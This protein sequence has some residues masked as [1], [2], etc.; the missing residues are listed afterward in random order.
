MLRCAAVLDTGAASWPPRWLAMP[1]FQICVKLSHQQGCSKD[2]EEQLPNGQQALM[3]AIIFCIG[4]TKMAPRA[5]CIPLY[6]PWKGIG[7]WPS[8]AHMGGHMG[9]SLRSPIRCTRCTPS[10]R[11][12]CKVSCARRRFHAGCR[13]TADTK[14]FFSSSHKFDRTGTSALQSIEDLSAIR[15]C[16]LG[17][18]MAACVSRATTDVQ[19]SKLQ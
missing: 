5:I 10:I 4:A 12:N 17:V 6:T 14:M 13:S 16:L 18:A 19:G 2:K 8:H 1:P 7:S 9:A 3:S 15:G 11:E